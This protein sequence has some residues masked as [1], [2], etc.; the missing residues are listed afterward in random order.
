M[1]QKGFINIYYTFFIVAVITLI[2]GGVYFALNWQ[3][4]EQDFFIER[5]LPVEAPVG[6]GISIIG[7]GFTPT[8]NSL[9]FGNLSYINNLVSSDG[10]TITFT[11]PELFDACNPTGT[12]CAEFVNRLFPGQMYEV[13]VINANGQTNSVNFTVSFKGIHPDDPT[14]TLIP[15]PNS[16]SYREDGT[17]PPGYINYGVPL[18]CV[19]PEYYESCKTRPGGC[20]ICLA[21]GS[22][23]DTPLGSV[24]VKDLKV[25]M[26]VWTTDKTGQRVS[27][28][29]IKTSKAPV[30]P[31]HQM[32][33]LVLND[34]R[35][36]FVS[37]GHPIIDGR[38]VGNLA[39]GDSYNGTSVISV[40]R[41]SYDEN[42]TYDILPSGDTGF[43]WSNGILMGSTLR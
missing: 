8:E 18:E 22:L 33:H 12:V 2:G 34:G 26:P 37:P 31:T 11:L 15:K 27:G 6:A 43:Y 17:C 13:V 9:K 16:T 3:V 25:G 35:E 42:A 7:S 24:M 32:V 23:I 36:L 40:E 4:Q 5:I 19:T 14:P 29:I 30:P 10:K 38:I 39:P 1:N 41:V 21:S 28:I 20:P